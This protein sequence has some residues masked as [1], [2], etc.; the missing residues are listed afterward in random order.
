MPQDLMPMLE[1][2]K[3]LKEWSQMLV[4]AQTGMLAVIA[5][6]VRMPCPPRSRRWLSGSIL[7]F[8]L[9]VI[10]A[11]NVV[12]TIPWLIQQLPELAR[13]GNDIYQFRN[14]V[15]IKVWLLAMGQHLSFV[16]GLVCFL[17]YLI[18]R[19]AADSPHRGEVRQEVVQD[20]GE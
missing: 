7:F 12:G 15:G 10:I 16:V 20:E 13:K 4:V 19:S 3:L 9:S 18:T 2:M 8:V 6:F 14:W 5:A 1:A 17:V 11:L